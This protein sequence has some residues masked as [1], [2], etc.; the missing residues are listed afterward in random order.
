MPPKDLC[1][2]TWSLASGGIWGFMGPLRS[3]VAR[4]SMSLGAS[5]EVF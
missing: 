5:C 4:G 2:N 3:S 1:L